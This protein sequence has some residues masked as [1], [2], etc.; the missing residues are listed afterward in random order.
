MD[1][2]LDQASARRVVDH[3]S[4][5]NL[6]P[7]KVESAM[8]CA[9]AMK[10]RYVDRVPEMASGVMLA[11]RAVHAVLEA[12]LRRILAGGTLMSAQDMDDLY[13]PTWNRETAEEEG[14]ESFLGWN[15]DD[16]TE[17]V[18]RE[19]SRA[20]VRIAREEILPKIKPRL[21][22]HRLEWSIPCEG[23]A[24]PMVGYLDLL[25]ED[26]VLSDWKTTAGK[27]SARAKTTWMQFAGYAMPLSEDMG[28]EVIEARKIFL[29]RGK[30]PRIEIAPFT[31]V[32]QQRAWFAHCAKEVWK[33]TR[34]GAYVP[35]T[36]GWWCTKK[37]CG[38]YSAVCPYGAVAKGDE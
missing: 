26:G 37:F 27:V 10:F 21:V 11:G 2:E 25:E 17:E 34:A 32:P 24:V 7:T 38:F 4:M 9:L 29:V 3:G 36:N 14:K 18:V 19:E 33:S 31:I 8:L 12:A 13:L 5:R 16:E 28:R 20:L 6:S 15:Y 30:R 23:G 35:N 22:E 1:T